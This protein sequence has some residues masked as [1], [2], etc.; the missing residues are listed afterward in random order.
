MAVSS[1][2][3]PLELSLREAVTALLYLPWLRVSAFR[4]V[5]TALF[6]AFFK[7]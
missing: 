6:L 5:A 2:P 4:R 1:S 7:P 3:V